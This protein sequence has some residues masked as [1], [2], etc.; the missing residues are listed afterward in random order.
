M[1]VNVPIEY[2]TRVSPF[3]LLSLEHGDCFLILQKNSSF[4]GNV[5]VGC[6]K[7]KL[8]RAFQRDLSLPATM[9]TVETA[10]FTTIEATRETTRPFSAGLQLSKFYSPV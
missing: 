4:T 10:M 5:L 9:T 8:S 7:R 6:N 1:I 2:C 3:Y